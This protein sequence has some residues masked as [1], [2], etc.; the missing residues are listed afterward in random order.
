MDY[1]ENKDNFEYVGDYEDEFGNFEE[2]D[3]NENNI[4]IKIDKVC[5]SGS[6][7]NKVDIKNNKLKKEKAIIKTKELDKMF[8]VKGSTLQKQELKNRLLYIGIPLDQVKDEEKSTLVDV[9]DSLIKSQHNRKKLL[10]YY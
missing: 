4:N 8:L 1:M 9:Y 2:G 6:K 5:K 7:V 3:Q 10:K